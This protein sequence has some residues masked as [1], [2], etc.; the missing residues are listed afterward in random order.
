VAGNYKVSKVRYRGLGYGSKG[1]GRRK[2]WEN[3]L[4]IETRSS[5]LSFLRNYLSGGRIHFCVLSDCIL[6]S[7]FPSLTA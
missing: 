5:E 7:I 1:T 4:G 6:Y 3:E 2:E